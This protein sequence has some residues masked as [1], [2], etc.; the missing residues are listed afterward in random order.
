MNR[1]CILY[2]L[3]LLVVC[4]AEL[5]ELIFQ[6]FKN[7]IKKYNKKYQSI[8]EYLTRFEVFKRNMISSIS[9]EE[10]SYKKGIT[11]FSDLTKEE[12]TKTYLNLDYN[13]MTMSNFNPTF[14]KSKNDAPDS[15]DWRDYNVVSPIKKQ[16]YCTASWA[17]SVIGNLESL[18]AI[19]KKVFKSLSEQML[20]DCD[21]SDSGCG[22]GSITTAYYWIKRNGGIMYEV[23]Y[24]IKEL[25]KFVNQIRV[26][27]QICLL[28]DI[29]Y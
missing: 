21:T 13:A 15:F 16:G 6:Q 29:K 23:D 28:Q 2:L 8:N 17:F 25:D 3:S 5:D 19:E 20:I 26:N 9:S 1:I 27:M 12:F 11:T 24:L 7:F 18:Y 10:K 14:K 4:N 22:G